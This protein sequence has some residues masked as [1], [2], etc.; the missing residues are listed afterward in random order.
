MNVLHGVID[1]YKQAEIDAEKDSENGEIINENLDE[2]VK[3][4]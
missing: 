4:Y 2:V 3:N 1:V